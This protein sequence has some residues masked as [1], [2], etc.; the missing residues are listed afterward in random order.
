M[1][2]LHL[3]TFSIP[4]SSIKVYNTMHE[5]LRKSRTIRSAKSI[6][7]AATGR[8]E[9]NTRGL[10]TTMGKPT[11]TLRLETE[12]KG[13]RPGSFKGSAPS[14]SPIAT[15]S[16][17]KERIGAIATTRPRGP[18]VERSVVDTAEDRKGNREAL[19]GNLPYLLGLETP[20]LNGLELSETREGCQRARRPSRGSMAQER[21][22]ADKETGN[23]GKKR[24]SS[25]L[26]KAALCCRV[27]L[28]RHGL[29]RARR[30]YTYAPR[31]TIG[32]RLSMLSPSLQT[33]DGSASVSLL[34]PRTSPSQR[35][36]NSSDELEDLRL[37]RRSLLSWISGLSIQAD[38]L[39]PTWIGAEQ[40]LGLNGC[41]VMLPSLTLWREFGVGANI[42]TLIIM[43]QRISKNSEKRFMILLAVG[44]NSRGCLNRSSGSLNWPSERS[45]VVCVISNRGSIALK[46]V[47]KIS[48]ILTKSG[49]ITC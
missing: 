6:G 36:S 35:L 47:R 1:H 49:Q 7:D 40:G 45:K 15:L 21:L 2:T 41:P 42:A 20:A 8:R 4:N 22:A 13:A 3:L 12:S 5:T 46:L 26:T 33:K 39:R 43:R 24:R 23:S 34:S 17:A 10:P 28:G 30:P 25:S 19:W 37:Q 31:N 38:R 11:S 18:R 16:A 27:S 48:I 32:S 44:V 14:S 29:L 9:V